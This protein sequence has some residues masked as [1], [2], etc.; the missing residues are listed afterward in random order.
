MKVLITGSCGFVGRHIV[1]RCLNEGWH[2]TGVDDLSS[3]VVDTSYR[4]LTYFEDFRTWCKDHPC[5]YDLIFH[6]AAV[7]GGRLKIEGDPLAVATDLAIDADLFNWCAKGKTRAKIVYFS[8]SAVYPI[9]LQQ[10]DYHKPLAES[11]VDFN[12]IGIPDMT[13]GWAKLTGEYLA[14]QAVEKYALDVVIY[15]PFSG[16]GHDQ[17]LDYPF[18]SIIKRV[19]QGENPVTVWGSGDQVRDFI[20]I[21]DVVD[22][23][24]A[25]MNKLKPGEVLNLGSGEGISFKALALAT[26][27]AL[28]RNVRVVTDPS[29]PEGVFFRVADVTKLH[30][31]YKPTRELYS[32]IVECAKF[33]EQSLDKASIVI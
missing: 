25:T 16:Y 10:R 24:F 19:L 29:K 27:A 23:V 9:S 28:D 7:V 18:P 17:A 6:C 4:H 13:Y 21:D 30:S 2:V 11:Y 26:A 22:A 8:S 12:Y 3:G 32:G 31:L 5:D 20:H 33:L 1:K 14:R 15:R